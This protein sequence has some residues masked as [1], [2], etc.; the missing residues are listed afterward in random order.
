MIT[1]DFTIEGDWVTIPIRT[2]GSFVYIIDVRL[3][4]IDVVVGAE[5]STSRGV[6]VSTNDSL[7]ASETIKVKAP[8]GVSH[9]TVVRD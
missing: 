5:I 8:S 6:H 1:E 2:N 3:S 4:G 9:I 7:K